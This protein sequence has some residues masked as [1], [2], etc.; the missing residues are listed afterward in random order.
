LQKK[1]ADQVRYN[2]KPE[3]G[4]DAGHSNIPNLYF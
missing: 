1:I 2:K 3:E 4:I